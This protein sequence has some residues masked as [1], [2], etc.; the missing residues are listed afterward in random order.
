VERRLPSASFDC[1]RCGACCVANFDSDVYVHLTDQDLDLLDQGGFTRMALPVHRNGAVLIYDEDFHALQTKVVKR[2]R[3]GW[4]FTV[5][6]AFKG[7]VGGLCSCGI[8]DYRPE[9]CRAFKPGSS[10]CVDARI[11]AGLTAR[12]VA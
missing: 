3:D 2:R 11:E 8:Y 1:T 12:P 5:C 9:A 4:E 7:T 6:K 10:D